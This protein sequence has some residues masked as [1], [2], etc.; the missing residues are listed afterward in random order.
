MVGVPISQNYGPNGQSIWDK[1]AINRPV[2]SIFSEDDQRILKTLFYP[3]RSEYGYTSD[4]FVQF[5]SDLTA[6][7]PKLWEMFDFER[8]LAE[9]AG[10]DPKD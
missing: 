1:S 10:K 3:I 5:Q 8:T 7:K 6:I 4:T 9:A 2:G